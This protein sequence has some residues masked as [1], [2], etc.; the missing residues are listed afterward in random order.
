MTI[1]TP[2]FDKDAANIYYQTL[3][4][5]FK[6]EKPKAFII[7]DKIVLP[8]VTSVKIDKKK[9]V[10]GNQIIQVYKNNLPPDW[11]DT[12]MASKVKKAKV[13]VYIQ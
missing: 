9:K 1:N 8:E 10:S 5:Y 4:R 11:F 13:K 2:L 3:H 7:D 6:K 12:W